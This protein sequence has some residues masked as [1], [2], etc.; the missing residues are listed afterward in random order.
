MTDQSTIFGGADQNA[1]P[2]ATTT[3]PDVAQPATASPTGF[4][5]WVGPGKKYSSVEEMARA[6]IFA[7]EH[8]KS[9]EGTLGEL[10]EDLSKRQAVSDM[11]DQLT[12]T[13][14][15]QAP[16][17]T[18]PQEQAPATKEDLAPTIAELVKQQMDEITTAEQRSKNRS[19]VV[20]SLTQKYGEK[21]DE[22]YRAK[23]G[24]LGMSL[25]ALNN[26]CETS[27]QAALALLG[28]SAAPTT[29]A[30]S[31]PSTGAPQ[32][33]SATSTAGELSP[34]TKEYYTNLRR[35]D[36]RKYYSPE[37]QMEMVRN[38]RDLTGNS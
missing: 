5:E 37:I 34:G 3:T 22:S 35:T 12:S 16:A 33:H 25:D 30:P 6:N 2:A 20:E 38:A 10:R 29:P 4:E 7:Q 31:T 27:P 36:P 9:V 11:M 18:P 21:A 8:I 1:A 32:S 19:Q 17:G 23:A 26:L 15:T 28:G 24:E 14:T 13:V